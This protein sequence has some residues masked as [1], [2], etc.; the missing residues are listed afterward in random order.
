MT[1]SKI[2]SIINEIERG[3]ISIEEII[4]N[5]K[6]ISEILNLYIL[7]NQIKDFEPFRQFYKILSK[8]CKKKIA[9]KLFII[10]HEIEKEQLKM[11]L[12]NFKLSQNEFEKEN[13][14]NF[15]VTLINTFKDRDFLL[16]FF[17]KNFKQIQT[18]FIIQAIKSEDDFKYFFDSVVKSLEDGDFCLYEKGVSV[19]N[20][21]IKLQ[22]INKNEKDT[23]IKKN[24]LNNK[25]N[26]NNKN[27]ENDNNNLNNKL[28]K[29]NKNDEND[30][31]NYTNNNDMSLVKQLS[32]LNIK[33]NSLK[34]ISRT[35]KINFLQEALK[36]FQNDDYS[37]LNMLPAL[38]I[39]SSEEILNKYGE[40]ILLYLIPLNSGVIESIGLLLLHRNIFL[41]SLKMFSK[42]HL[43]GKINLVYCYTHLIEV[44]FYIQ[45]LVEFFA[46]KNVFESDCKVMRRFMK[47]FLMKLYYFSNDYRLISLMNKY[48]D[49]KIL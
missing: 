43:L 6:N 20:H 44:G 33:E 30:N 4:K 8:E 32:G 46:E 31:N 39:N 45:D 2:R 40:K 21:F 1:T 3:K 10:D 12:K 25:L 49:I 37:C 22:E 9:N 28:N 47:I 18:E 42:I 14:Y 16:H 38:I 29:N 11:N 19:M 41:K 7:R 34:S 36:L 26:K 24:K 23:F 17:A 13:Y 15:N 35:P 27:D 48:G 5:E